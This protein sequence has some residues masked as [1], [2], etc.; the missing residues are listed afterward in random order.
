MPQELARHIRDRLSAGAHHETVAD[1]LVS[2]GWPED[3][4]VEAFELAA[5]SHVLP[6]AAPEF[7]VMSAAAHR[8]VHE[9]LASGAHPELVAD[10]LKAGGWPEDTIV[11]AFEH[12]VSALGDHRPPLARAEATLAVS[13]QEPIRNLEKLFEAKPEP[14]PARQARFSKWEILFFSLGVVLILISIAALFFRAQSQDA[15][16]ARQNRNVPASGGFEVTN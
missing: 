2:A 4:I 8:Y 13:A 11:H 3:E 12:A 6:V 7:A 5:S 16:D 15:G 1:E 9:Q 14:H 10:E